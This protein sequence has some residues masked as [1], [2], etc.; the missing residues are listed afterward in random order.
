MTKSE[1]ITARQQLNTLLRIVNDAANCQWKIEEYKTIL[2]KGTDLSPS[3]NYWKAKLK[4]QTDTYDKIMSEYVEAYTEFTTDKTPDYIKESILLQEEM[5]RDEN[6]FLD[7][8]E[9][10]TQEIERGG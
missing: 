2:E 8:T 4:I 9:E 6:D 3:E 5:V 1:L 7:M 10:E